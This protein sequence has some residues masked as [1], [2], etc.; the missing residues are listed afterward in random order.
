MTD[1]I[2]ITCPKHGDFEQRAGNHVHLENGCPKCV[3]G[4]TSKE[5]KNLLEFVSKHYHG[6]IVENDRKTLAGKE[7]D[8]FIPELLLGIE[9]HGIYWH[10]ETVHGRNY[11]YDKWATAKEKGIRLIQIYSTEWEQ[12][13]AILESKIINLFGNSKKIMARKTNVVAVGRHDKNQFLTESHL[14]GPDSSKIWLGLEYLGELVAVMTFGPSRFN[15]EY[16]YELVR[17]CSKRGVTVTGGAGKLLSHFRSG[18]PGSIV[19]YADKRYSEGEM[20]D[21]IG[22]RLDGETQPSFSY[23]NIRN[24]QLYNRMNFQKQFLKNMPGYSDSLTEYE[25]MQLNG[26]D[27][28]WDAGQYRYVME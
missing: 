14:Q 5:E 21:A 11:H 8:I 15:K 28:I 6:E 10:L 13:R 3:P 12:K 26:Y 2:T 7:I 18:H 22:F 17:Y 20:Y 4:S 27:R 1:I 24:N 25:V 19:T 23:F 16:K 9:Y